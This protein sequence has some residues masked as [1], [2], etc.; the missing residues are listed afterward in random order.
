MF[1]LYCFIAC[2]NFACGGE[3]TQE[4]PDAGL[5]LP[6][7]DLNETKI[8][9]IAKETLLLVTGK[10][11]AVRPY[12]SVRVYDLYEN[13]DSEKAKGDGS[14]A[15]VTEKINP[16]KVGVVKIMATD[17]FCLPTIKEFLIMPSQE[18]CDYYHQNEE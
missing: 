10:A 17:S 14:F 11:Y 1:F 15:F 13:A 7:C 3:E 16:L 6:N 9:V 5:H 18:A 8:C 4:T 12:G 2:L